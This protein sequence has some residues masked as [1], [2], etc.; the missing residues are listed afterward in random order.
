MRIGFTY[1]TCAGSVANEHCSTIVEAPTGTW[2]AQ[3]EP[4]R[5][6]D[7]PAADR[8]TRCE[9][10]LRKKRHSG[11]SFGYATCT[12]PARKVCKNCGTVVCGTHANRLPCFRCHADAW[13]DI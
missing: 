13:L 8:P 7:A 4:C 11:H 1:L 5:K 6:A 12:A 9:R 3:C 10:V 2:T